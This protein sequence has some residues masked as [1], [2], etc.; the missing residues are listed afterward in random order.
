M[1]AILATDPDEKMLRERKNQWKALSDN[2]RSDGDDPT[3]ESPL[4][5]ETPLEHF[6]LLVLEP[7]QVDY[8]CLRGN[9]QRR[10]CY[11]L[12]KGEWRETELNA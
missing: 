1:R 11:H 3:S 2:A 9:P 7:E 12:D 8:L 4:D 5:P 6:V 10:T